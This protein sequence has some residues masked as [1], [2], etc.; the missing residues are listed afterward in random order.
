MAGVIA[1]SPYSSAVPNN[2][3]A[4][5]SGRPP[6]CR[7][8]IGVASEASARMPPSPR[9]SARRMKPRYFTEITST[10]D[11]KTSERTPSTS[12]VLTASPCSGMNDSRTA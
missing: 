4:I 9:L 7:M 8:P 1:P 10:S 2:P 3:S 5:R 12:S 6:S 11:Q